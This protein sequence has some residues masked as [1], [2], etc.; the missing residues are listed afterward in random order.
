[1]RWIANGRMLYSPSDLINFM[2]SDFVSWMDQL[3]RLFPDQAEP[4]EADESVKILQAHGDR[5]ERDFLASL[6]AEGRDV[7]DVPLNSDAIAATTEAMRQGREIIY[8]GVLALAPFEGRS[9]FLVRRDGMVSNYGDYGYEVW[10]TKLA[11]KPKPYFIIQLCCYAEMLCATQGVLPQEIAIVLGTKETHTFRTEDYFYYYT[12][13]KEAFLQFQNDFDAN[14]PPSHIELPSFSR[15]H[16]HGQKMLEERDSLARVA[17]IRRIQM[18]K[19]EK[20]GIETMTSL[21]TSMDMHIPKMSPTT[22]QTLKQQARLQIE[23]IGLHRPKYEVIPPDKLDDRTGLGLLPPASRL[24]IFFDMEGY[25]HIEGGLEYLFGASYL[26]NDSLKFTD[27]WAHDRAEEKKAFE[28]FID[29]TIARWKDDPGMHVYHYASYEVSAMRRLMGRYGTRETEVDDLLRNEIFVDL[30]QIV[31]QSLRV[32]EPSYSIKNIE[33]LYMDARSGAVS[34]ATDS[35]VFYERWLEAGDSKDWATSS[36]LE[37]I[38]NYNKD[39]CDSTVKLAQWLWQLQRTEGIQ[40]INKREQCGYFPRTEGGTE[41]D[42]SVDDKSGSGVAQGTKARASALALEMLSQVP[43]DPA[44]FET[45]DWWL[46]QLLAWLLCFHDREY[47][48]VYWK[49]FD[50]HSM[51]EE[52]LSDDIDCLGGLQRAG[53]WAEKTPGNRA[54]SLQF[55]Y[56]FD[57]AQETKL[58]VGSKIL[59]AHDLSANGEIVEFDR[60][61]GRVFIKTSE[62]KAHPPERASIIPKDFAGERSIADSILRTVETWCADKVLPVALEDFLLRRQPR[63]TGQ[64]TGSRIVSDDAEPAEIARVVERLDNSTLSIQGPPGSGKTYTAAFVIAHLLANNYRVGIT[65]NSHAAIEQLMK[66]VAERCVIENVNFDGVKIGGQQPHSAVQM[67]SSARDLF[68]NHPG[69]FNLIGGTA[70]AFSNADSVNAVDY[71]FVDEAGQVSVA[72][73]VGVSPSTRNI[74]LL[75]DQMQLDQPIQGFHPGDSGMSTLEYLLQDSATVPPDMG[76][77]LGTTRRM[78]PEICQLISSIVYESRLQSHPDTLSRTLIKPGSSRLLTKS[79]GIIFTPVTHFGNTQGSLEEVETISRLIEELLQCTFLSDEGQRSLTIEDILIVAPYNM[80]VRLLQKAWDGA[81]VGSVDKFQGQEAPVVIL[82]MCTSDG[83]SSPRG[84]EF[85]FSQNRLN[86]AISRAQCL[87][88]VVGNPDLQRASC[89]TI[90][91]IKLA[92]FFCKIAQ[93]GQQIATSAVSP[94]R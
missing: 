4:D 21:A 3:H 69:K 30:Y 94:Q 79:E 90:T 8:Q 60:D 10:D 17:N 44:E 58:A 33:H 56:A 73:L 91:Q 92:N 70:Y 43:S 85:I 48:P 47:K 81:A 14:L 86:V 61:T 40:Y 34:K 37:D 62:K 74:V 57:P 16:T 29:W 78:R 52:Q 5:H 18:A 82:S 1:M 11:R 53:R 80:Q 36:I 41:E 64:A 2:E 76:I 39:D 72:N 26:E 65:S 22:F 45:G 93:E 66:K 51:T 27:W 87:A 54:R 15:W 75:G 55:E 20:A 71:L 9:D 7:F 31:R 6:I 19:L 24:D 13:L 84:I 25:P 63:I 12:S 83:A 68:Q 42:P 50:R 89:N 88:I 23:S 28:D 32:G 46:H 77:F 49:R 59:F 35:V 67:A 38:R